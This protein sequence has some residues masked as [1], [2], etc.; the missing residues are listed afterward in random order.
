MELG[1][2]DRHRV[3]GSR[4]GIQRQAQS[5][6]AKAMT[7]HIRQRSPCSWEVKYDLGRDPLTGK[8]KTRFVT[9][10]GGKKAAQQELRRLLNAVDEGR[11]VEPSK[12]TIAEYIRGWLDAATNLSPKTKERY[13]QLAERQIF[14]HLGAIPLQKLRPAQIHEWHSLVLKSGGA[15]G[16]PLSARTVGHAHR[17]LHRALERALSLEELGRNVSSAVSPPKVAAAEIAILSAEQI[18]H[19]LARLDGHPLHPIV[20]LAL[21]SGLRRGE[22]C[23]LAWGA[24]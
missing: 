13:R 9:V 1:R 12:V 8:R 6:K 19:V 23:G 17:V 14:P 10:R 7:G 18:A 16:G 3:A 22:L 20:A 21:G 15:R 11:D 4:R 2:N 24:V 5:R